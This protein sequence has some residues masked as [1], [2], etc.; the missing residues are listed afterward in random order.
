MGNLTQHHVPCAA[1]PRRLR[2]LTNHCCL[3]H[4][5]FSLLVLEKVSLTDKISLKEEMRNVRK[6]LKPS[7][8][9]QL[10]QG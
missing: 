7:F 9:L 2:L 8:K 6:L 4:F 1:R 10:L 3:F 5:S